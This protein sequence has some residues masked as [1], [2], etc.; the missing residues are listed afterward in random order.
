MGCVAVLFS[1]LK[2]DGKRNVLNQKLRNEVRQSMISALVTQGIYT[3]QYSIS[4]ETTMA[5]KS[6]I[7]H[8]RYFPV[9]DLL[10]EKFR[11]EPV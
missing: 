3:K 11:T 1:L 5:F 10:I 8:Y 9:F 7:V 4:F 2:K 6:E